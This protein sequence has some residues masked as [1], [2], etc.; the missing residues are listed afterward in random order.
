MMRTCRGWRRVEVLQQRRAD[1]GSELL[2]GRHSA[3]VSVGLRVAREA[4]A[5]VQEGEG[6]HAQLR[7]SHVEHVTAQRDGLGVRVDV[8]AAAA[9]V[10]GGAN[11]R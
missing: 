10:E 6:G 8:E 1:D 2:E 9:D 4:A 11:D 7:L 5:Q 3:R